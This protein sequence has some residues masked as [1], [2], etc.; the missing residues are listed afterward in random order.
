MPNKNTTPKI[1]NPPNKK[2]GRVEA[3]VRLLLENIY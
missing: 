2:G 3:L 1:I